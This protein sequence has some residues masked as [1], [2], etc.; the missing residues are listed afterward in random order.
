MF[1]FFKRKKKFD[2]PLLNRERL[3]IAD[4]E[5]DFLKKLI[6]ALPAKYS[7]L[8]NQLNHDFLVGKMVNPLGEEGSFTFSIDQLQ[9]KK[10]CKRNPYYRLKG[11]SIFNHRKEKFE[12]VELDI[13]DNIIVGYYAPDSYEIYDMGRIEIKIIYE[14]RAIDIVMKE[15]KQILVPTEIKKLEEYLSFNNIFEIELDGKT[16]Y[17]IHDYEDGN[18][19]GLTLAGE[20][21]GLFHD[22]YK[23]EL[24]FS[25]VEAFIEQ[26][27]SGEFS[28]ENYFNNSMN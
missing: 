2:H 9:E 4:S 20:I 11:L 13:V 22:P 1:G 8:N 26:L 21:Y 25:D 15:L 24:I 5:L 18:Y 19:L 10:L 28:L 27:E 6:S 16:F 23:I 3:P 12:A 17:T 14:D 7:F